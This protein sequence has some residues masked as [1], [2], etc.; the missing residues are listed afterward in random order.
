MKIEVIKYVLMVENMERAIRFYRDVL[1]L[2]MKFESPHWS[3][4]VFGESVIGLYSG[5]ASEKKLTG[6]SFQVSNI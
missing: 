6:L 5:G 3:E 1:G 4:L 2:D